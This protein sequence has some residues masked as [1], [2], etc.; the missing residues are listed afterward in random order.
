MSKV[1]GERY[2]PILEW[3]PQIHHRHKYI[4]EEL[5]KPPLTMTHGDAHIENVFF[6][7][8]FSGGAAFIDFGNMMFSQGMYDI[9]F[10]VVNSLEPEVRR[11]ME[12]QIVEHYQACLVANGVT[13]YTRE[14]AWNDYV[15]NLWRPLISVCAIAPSIESD[16]KQGVGLFAE[17]PTQADEQMRQMY[18]K[19]NER[20]VSALLDHKWLD[21]I[22]E[23][24]Q[25]CGLCSCISFCY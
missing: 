25:H 12:R 22:L 6:H 17:K 20:I 19:L 5:F 9:A 24:S 11:A 13:S 10:F 7:S 8:R 3:L 1:Y 2:K 14:R 4:L 15:L 21:R 16:H 23:G 18:D